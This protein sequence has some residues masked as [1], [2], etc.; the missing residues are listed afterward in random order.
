MLF[1]EDIG[2]IQIG[3]HFL[4]DNVWDIYSDEDEINPIGFC[5]GF[6]LPMSPV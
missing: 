5:F 6:I 4:I 3:S 1:S 2:S